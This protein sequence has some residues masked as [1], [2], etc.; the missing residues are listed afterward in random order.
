MEE[1]E[2]ALGCLEYISQAAVFHGSSRGFSQIIAVVS[3]KTEI[4][5]T[6]IRNNLKRII[7]EY[8]IPTI[9]HVVEE[10]PKNPNGKVDRRK[11]QEIYAPHA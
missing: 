2:I 9:F 11:L 5:E 1:I 10:L 8:M 4:E 6:E 3:A 7:P